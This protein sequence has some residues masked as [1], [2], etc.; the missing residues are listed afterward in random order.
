M[1]EAEQIRQYIADYGVKKCPPRKASAPNPP[2][3]TLTARFAQ[4]SEQAWQ[5]RA[6]A[7]ASAEW[8]QPAGG[9]DIFVV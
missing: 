3:R 1:D 9:V 7:L 4:A 2:K 5:R 6:A 8:R